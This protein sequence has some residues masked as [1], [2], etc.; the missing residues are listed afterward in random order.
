MTGI[1]CPIVSKKKTYCMKKAGSRQFQSHSFLAI[2]TITTWKKKATEP[3]PS[4]KHELFGF[5]KQQEW[6]YKRYNV[7]RSSYDGFEYY[8][9][10]A[11]GLQILHIT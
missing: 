7:V 4:I 10:D 9:S 1:K 6:Q 11:R 2:V 5:V 3:I 8:I